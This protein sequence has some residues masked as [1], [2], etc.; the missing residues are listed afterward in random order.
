MKTQ[1]LL[2]FVVIM[3]HS[4]LVAS[5]LLGGNLFRRRLNIGNGIFNCYR[6]KVSSAALRSSVGSVPPNSD[7]ES[8]EPTTDIPEKIDI[9]NEFSNLGLLSD[10]VNG[11][12][13]QGEIACFSFALYR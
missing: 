11:L 12:A 2:A 3:T 1:L 10:L 4:K 8:V 13:A 6:H 9:F 7:M 5:Y